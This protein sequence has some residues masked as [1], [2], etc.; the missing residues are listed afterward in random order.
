MPPPELN[1]A[2]WH[3][4]LKRSR[5][6]KFNRI[7]PTH[8]GIFNDPGW[9]LDQVEKELTAAEKWLETVMPSEP[10]I[11][12]LRRKFPAWVEEQARAQGLSPDTVRAYDLANPLGMSA[13]G[14]MR[15]WKK[16][17]MAG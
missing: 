2:R 16:V 8:F 3:E 10:E 5:K 11:E 9:H 14:L 17:R 13:D 6:E 1:F 15:Y 4:T 12:E 7:A